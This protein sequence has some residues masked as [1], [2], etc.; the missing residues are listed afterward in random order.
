MLTFASTTVSLNV[1]YN[2]E[3][4]EA[5]NRIIIIITII[6]TIIIMNKHNIQVAWPSGLGA[7]AQ[8]KSQMR[9]EWES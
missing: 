3:T 9:L 8:D 4:N 2:D 7:E 5:N 1:N 6:I